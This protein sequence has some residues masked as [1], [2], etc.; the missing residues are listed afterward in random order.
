MA[1][2]RPS[3]RVCQLFK[4]CIYYI[5]IYLLLLL[6]TKVNE[7]EELFVK[8]QTD[9]ALHHSFSKNIKPLVAFSLSTGNEK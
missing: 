6:F 9:D 5:H 4:K 2:R 1:V 3:F 7:F 8:M